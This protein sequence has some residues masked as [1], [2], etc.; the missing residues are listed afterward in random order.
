MKKEKVLKVVGK[1]I[2]MTP[3]GSKV[4]EEYTINVVLQLEKD[5]APRSQ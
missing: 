4:E 3:N 2:K 5:S 1:H